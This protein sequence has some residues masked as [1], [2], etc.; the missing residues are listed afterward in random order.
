MALPAGSASLLSAGSTKSFCNHPQFFQV[1]HHIH[2]LVTPIRRNKETLY[3]H[4]DDE[5][6]SL[7]PLVGI[8][9]DCCWGRLD[10]R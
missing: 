2:T 8:P 10:I 7:A 9:H 3:L 5:H 4:I 6:G 1:E